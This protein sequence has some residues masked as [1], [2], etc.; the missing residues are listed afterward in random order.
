MGTGLCPKVFHPETII[1]KRPVERTLANT[2]EFAIEGNW[3]KSSHALQEVVK[4]E[5]SGLHTLKPEVTLGQLGF[6]DLRRLYSMMK[7]VLRWGR[8][9]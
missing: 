8:I 9:V 7:V 6:H 3:H 5:D 2:S 4:L 1:Y